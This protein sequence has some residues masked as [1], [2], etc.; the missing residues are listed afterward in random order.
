MRIMRKIAAALPLDRNK[1]KELS[2][3]ITKMKKPDKFYLSGKYVFVKCPEKY[4][5]VNI[6]I[7]MDKVSITG[8]MHTRHTSDILTGTLSIDYYH[9]VKALIESGLTIEEVYDHIS[10]AVPGVS[11][12]FDTFGER[13]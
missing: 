5:V 11:K 2:T 1:E 8:L 12:E 9:P 13:K 4:H 7:S 6:T 3:V 10:S